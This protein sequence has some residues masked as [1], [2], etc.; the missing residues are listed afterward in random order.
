[1]ERRYRKILNHLSLVQKDSLVKIV[2]TKISR[3]IIRINNFVTKH[4]GDDLE[5]IQADCELFVT[6][7]KSKA[8]EGSKKFK[9]PY[10]QLK[11]YFAFTYLILYAILI[12]V[13]YF[14]FSF[15]LSIYKNM[16]MLSN[17]KSEALMKLSKVHQLAVFNA[18]QKFV[19]ATYVAPNNISPI[20]N[21][22][23]TNT[24][25]DAF[26]QHANNFG[27]S[28]DIEKFLSY[29]STMNICSLNDMIQYSLIAVK[30]TEVEGEVGTTPAFM[31]SPTLQKFMEQLK[32]QHDNEINEQQLRRKFQES[33]AHINS[34]SYYIS[35]QTLLMSI[36]TNIVSY[37]QLSN[38]VLG[39]T[40]YSTAYLPI[41]QGM[42]IQ[43]SQHLL[44]LSHYHD[45]FVVL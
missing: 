15:D 24:S 34:L 39:Q 17:K 36:K 10:S 12:I 23:L 18:V 13:L 43:A 27:Y 41:L 26:T 7:S 11:Y 32:V 45:I 9:V 19:N 35:P 14:V 3:T 37:Y 31:S 4:C 6:N 5:K 25:F 33:Q 20:I 30:C 40:I 42:M 1:M 28:D 22:V 21:E 38:S 29:E 8:T 2:E 44:F 16:N